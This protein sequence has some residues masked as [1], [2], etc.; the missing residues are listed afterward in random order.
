MKSMILPQNYSFSYKTLPINLKQTIYSKDQCPK[1]TLFRH[2]LLTFASK[3]QQYLINWREKWNVNFTLETQ[4][5]AYCDKS[6]GYSLKLPFC[7]LISHAYATYFIYAKEISTVWPPAGG[8]GKQTPPH[9]GSG[10]K[11]ECC[12]PR[13]AWMNY[14]I[15]RAIIAVF[16]ACLQYVFAISFVTIATFGFLCLWL[17]RECRT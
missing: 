15:Y 1:N 2:R 14:W 9:R 11:F 12:G 4:I 5:S 17:R 16:R 3:T 7:T 6:A 10:G 8:R 13:T